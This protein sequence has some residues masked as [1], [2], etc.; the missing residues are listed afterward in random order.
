MKKLL[1]LIPVALMLNSCS[2]VDGAN[3]SQ[4]KAVNAVAGKKEKKPAAMQNMLDSWL[5]NEW[6]PIVSGT[7]APT[8]DTKVKIVPNED[9]SA[10]LV[11]AKTGVVLKEM[12]KEQV[13]KQKEVQK[14]YQEEDRA[15]TLQEYVDKMSVYSSTHVSDDEDSHTKKIN[16]M[17][18]IGTTKR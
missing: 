13:K 5:K 4:N 12:T 14:K 17:P 18:V 10:K 11:E 6:N 3:P 2:Q 7:E 9:G 1:L 15:F 16:D 8:A